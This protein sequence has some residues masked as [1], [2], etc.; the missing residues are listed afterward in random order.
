M[1]GNALSSLSVE[2]LSDVEEFTVVEEEGVVEGGGE[3]I[4][5]ASEGGIGRARGEGQGKGMEA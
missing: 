4:L 2:S 3:D 1:T 5:A